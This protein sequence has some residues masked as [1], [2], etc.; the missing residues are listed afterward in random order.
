MNW[1]LM[2]I[3]ICAVTAINPVPA[4]VLAQAPVPIPVLT[5]TATMQILRLG[6]ILS[7]RGPGIRR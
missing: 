5:Q 7:S 1:I 6:G 4:L 3:A 2:A